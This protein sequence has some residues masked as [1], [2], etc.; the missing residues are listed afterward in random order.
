MIKE[1]LLFIGEADAERLLSVEDAIAASEEAFYGVGAGLIDPGQISL[2]SVGG[3]LNNFHTMPAVLKDKKVA[4]MKWISAFSDPLPGYPF[5]HGNLI[6]LSSTETGSPL[7]IVGAKAITNLRT[8]GGHGVVQAKYLA[9][10]APAVLSV[11]GCGVQARAGIRAFLVQF[12]TIRLIRIFSRSAGPVMQVRKEYAGRADVIACTDAEDALK[13]SDLVLVA[14]GART[15]LVTADMIRP[16]M[17]IIGIEGFR[18][19]D[20][21]IAKKGKWYLG[22]REVDI[23][24]VHDAE[25]DPRNGLSAD[26]VFSD[27][28]NVL[29]HRAPG[30][31]S[32]D[33][34]IVSTH[35]GMGAIDLECAYRVYRKALETGEGTKLLLDLI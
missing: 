12:P 4:G 8:A 23:N 34:I 7:A 13:G 10:P 6:I 18:D 1:E 27:L 20:T 9:N 16:G 25:L 28:T 14:S 2:L 26:D 19:I 32:E 3:G 24:M 30:R 35:M 29:N 22:C 11:F 21:E 31:V 15:P 5:T 33:E 17:T